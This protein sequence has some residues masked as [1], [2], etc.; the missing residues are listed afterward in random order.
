MSIIHNR[1]ILMSS[2]AKDPGVSIILLFNGSGINFPRPRKQKHQLFIS[3]FYTV[4][5]ILKGILLQRMSNF[6]K[7]FQGTL[8]SR[9]HII[10]RV[11]R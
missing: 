11:S 3:S 10:N 9:I 1:N 8:N 4:K 2:V 5:Y 7:I 6:V